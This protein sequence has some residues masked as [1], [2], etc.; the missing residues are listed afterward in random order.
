MKQTLER[1]YAA[2]ELGFAGSPSGPV[3]TYRV[4][5]TRKAQTWKLNKYRTVEVEKRVALAD[6]N[7]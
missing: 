1:R 2:R 4:V 6:R 7:M 5:P 3:R